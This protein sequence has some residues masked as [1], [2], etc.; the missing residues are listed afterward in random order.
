MSRHGWR[1]GKPVYISRWLNPVSETLL[2]ALNRSRLLSRKKLQRPLIPITLQ[3]QT[4]RGPKTGG[5]R[6]SRFAKACVIAPVLL[7]GGLSAAAAGEPLKL[8]QRSRVTAGNGYAPVMNHVSWEPKQTAIIVCDMWDSHHSLN[9]VKR[10]QEIAPRMNQVL[11]TARQRSVFIIHA[12]ASCREPDKDHA[13]RKRAQEAPKSKTLP[14]DIAKW[15][16]VIP[17]EEKGQYPLDQSDG[18][19]DTLDEPQRAWQAKLKAMGR[20]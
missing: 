3:E 11:E 17:S 14:A 8:I 19:D 2:Q 9:A 15:C 16:Y 13:A 1:S 12:P 20:K 6:M 5:R 10:V 4:R 18:G 7:A